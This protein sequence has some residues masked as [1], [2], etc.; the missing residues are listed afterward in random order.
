MACP[1]YIIQ[2]ILGVSRQIFAPARCCRKMR[3]VGSS[4]FCTRTPPTKLRC[5]SNTHSLFFHLFF[6]L[7]GRGAD[8]CP[9]SR[10]LSLELT[11]VR[12]CSRH[13]LSRCATCMAVQ[14]SRLVGG[15]AVAQ[16]RWWLKNCR[17]TPSRAQLRSARQKLHANKCATMDTN[18]W[19]RAAF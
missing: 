10:P 18:C 6:F 19:T 9:W 11:L 1:D 2:S 8:H 4:N 7:Q 13:I 16:A 3:P 5:S 17:P 12:L 15:A 14:Y